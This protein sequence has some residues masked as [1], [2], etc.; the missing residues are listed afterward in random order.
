[1]EHRNN[2][3]LTWINTASPYVWCLTNT[4]IAA[5]VADPALISEMEKGQRL[6]LEVVDSSVLKVSTTLPLN[7]FASAHQRAPTRTF[8]Q[9]VDE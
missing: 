6:Q 2:E 1:M 3:R 5:N 4:C 9:E 7:Q 8:E